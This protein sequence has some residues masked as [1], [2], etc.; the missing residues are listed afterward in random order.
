MLDIGK[1]VIVIGGFHTGKKGE[2]VAVRRT[3]TRIRTCE[4]KFDA[5]KGAIVEARHLKEEAFGG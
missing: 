1:R 3:A 5:G 4:V 2:V